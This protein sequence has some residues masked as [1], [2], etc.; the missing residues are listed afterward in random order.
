MEIEWLT[1]DEAARWLSVPLEAIQGAIK[2]GQLPVLRLG[3]HVRINRD[4]VL[5]LASGSMSPEG[6]EATTVSS[7]TDN[8]IPIPRG[9]QWVEELVRIDSF[10]YKWPK[11]KEKPDDQ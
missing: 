3:S 11:K 2:T 7:D 4:I 9:M 1:E 8:H 6:V 5:Q 10:Q